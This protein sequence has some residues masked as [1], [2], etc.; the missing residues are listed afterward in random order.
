MELLHLLPHLA[1]LVLDVLHP[2][3]ELQ[4]LLGVVSAQL[5]AAATVLEDLCVFVIAVIHF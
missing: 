4:L 3:L 5:V 2:H 1:K